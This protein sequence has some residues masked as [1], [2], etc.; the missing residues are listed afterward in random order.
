MGELSAPFTI[1]APSISRHLR[2]LESAALIVREREGQH[3]RCR[4]IANQLQ[5]AHDWLGE[6]SRFWGDALERL[7]QH[8]K[9]DQPKQQ[10]RKQ[11]E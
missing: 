6:Y 8:L 3:R 2:V 10:S 11:G 5:P 4:L 9:Q 1:S 7:D